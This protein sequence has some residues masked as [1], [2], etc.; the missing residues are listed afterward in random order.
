MS[1]SL[2]F[3]LRRS[4]W[5]DAIK[6]AGRAHFAAV[7]RRK[8]ESLCGRRRVALSAGARHPDYGRDGAAGGH[9]FEL[10]CAFRSEISSASS[11]WPPSGHWPIR[12]CSLELSTLGLKVSTRRK[13]A[14][15]ILHRPDSVPAPFDPG[16]GQSR[17][18]RAEEVRGGL[19]ARYRGYR[20]LAAD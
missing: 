17:T 2:N 8:R 14:G 13:W 10:V 3:S 1:I 12:R 20:T 4:F 16:S 9:L 19:F 15:K 6:S 7:V 18:A 5:S 11:M